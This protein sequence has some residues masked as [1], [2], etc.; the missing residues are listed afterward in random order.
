MSNQFRI[1]V[2]VLVCYCGYLTDICL[3]STAVSNEPNQLFPSQLIPPENV[4]ETG[5]EQFVIDSF[6]G[7]PHQK[8]DAVFDNPLDHALAVLLNRSYPKPDVSP[9]VRNTVATMANKLA[10]SNTYTPTTSDIERWISDTLNTNSFQSMLSNMQSLANNTLD[11]DILIAVGLQGMMAETSWEAACVLDATKAAEVENILE[12]RQGKEKGILGLNLENW[13]KVKPSPNSPAVEAGIREGDIVIAIDNKDV[14]SIKTASEALKILSGPPGDIVCLTVEREGEIHQFEMKRASKATL[15]I[16]SKVVALNIWYIKI[17]T[18][19][20]TGVGEKVNQLVRKEAAG[21]TRIFIL[22]LRDNVGGRAEESNAIANL[23]LDNRLLQILEFDEDKYLAFKST[24]G[25]VD[26]TVFLLTNTNTGSAA[27]MLA[28]ALR[29]NQKAKI[30]G[31]CSAGTLFGKDF[32]KLKNNQMII[33]RSRPTVLS[34]IGKN[35]AGNGITPD[36]E[37]KQKPE[38]T[39]N[40]VDTVLEFT[41]DLIRK[42]NS[43]ISTISTTQ[44]KVPHID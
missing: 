31:Q 3:V 42:S 27:E 30:V 35:Y 40:G 8:Q 2:L 16:Q 6:I 22:D 17:P 13:P 44:D 24:S 1:L 19:E 23:F 26:A 18:F 37:V 11:S 20:G 32:E 4:F 43:K 7:Q 12:A 9:L 34:P 41:L 29:D 15:Q 5:D 36:Y 25:A 33:F 21:G 14:K 10:K 38:D 39:A 28:M